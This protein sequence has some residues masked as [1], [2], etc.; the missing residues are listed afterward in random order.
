MQEGVVPAVAA[1]L[2]TKVMEQSES[3]RKG[4]AI[5]D[6]RR[7]LSFREQSDPGTEWRLLQSS[8]SFFE[9]SQALKRRELI[10]GDGSDDQLSLIGL[11]HRRN[12]SLSVVEAIAFG[13]DGNPPFEISYGHYNGQ[14]EEPRF[15]E[16]VRCDP[17]DRIFSSAFELA[18]CHGQLRVR[19][20]LG[21]DQ[22]GWLESAVVGSYEGEGEN[23]WSEK[24]LACEQP[25]ED[26]PLG[27]WLS[28]D[29]RLEELMAQ[30]DIHSGRLLRIYE[31]HWDGDG[32]LEKQRIFQ[33]D[34]SGIYVR[35]IELWQ[36]A[37]EGGLKEIV[38]YD[39]YSHQPER[40]YRI[41]LDAAGRRRQFSRF[42]YA[43]GEAV[44]RAVHI[45][46]RPDGLSVRRSLDQLFDPASGRPERSLEQHFDDDGDLC[47]RVIGELEGRHL[48]QWRLR[49]N[50]SREPERA[51]KL[52]WDMDDG[53]I[54]FESPSPP[55]PDFCYNEKQS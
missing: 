31:R 27:R 39:K 51:V 4:A 40:K 52:G 23:G 50:K 19:Y 42:D 55:L 41:L 33:F 37:P 10:V 43:E 18:D 22:A 12:G 11:D 35:A 3:A 28:A 46:Y 7:Y 25:F 45:F 36:R 14:G 24:P 21:Y 26:A 48:I 53:R 13:R 47:R 2:R 17:A 49:Y 6:F 20:G 54:A 34:S 30:H 15:K 9:E 29:G 16:I 8:D 1:R 5:I 32:E 38:I 44:R